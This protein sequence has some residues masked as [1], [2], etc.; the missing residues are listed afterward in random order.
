MLRNLRCFEIRRVGYFKKRAAP[1]LTQAGPKN[2]S[3]EMFHPSILSHSLT[4][5]IALLRL[6]ALATMA[7]SIWT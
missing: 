7:A 5:V 1:R 4:S 3:G 2:I 6:A